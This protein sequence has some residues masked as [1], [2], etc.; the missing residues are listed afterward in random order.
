MEVVEQQFS[1]S[2]KNIFQ[3][4]T[5]FFTSKLLAVGVELDLFTWLSQRPRSFAEIQA[6]FD[7]A[8][9]PCRIFLETLVSLNLLEIQHGLY[10]NSSLAETLLVRGRPDFQGPH[11]RLF[12]NLYIACDALKI[13]LFENRPV[14]QDY[15][16]F[17]DAEGKGAARYST[18][19][20]DSSV[21]PALVLP[22]YWDF[23][24]S[25]KV[26]DVGGGYGRL[27]LTLVSQH[28]TLETMLF[29]LPEV[30]TKAAELLQSYPHGLARRIH[31]HPGNFFRDPL[32]GGA[33]TIVMMRVTHDWPR[34]RV[35]L[36]ARKAFAALPRGGRLLIYET[37]KDQGPCPGDAALISLLLLLISPGGECRTFAEMRTLLYEVGFSHIELIPTVYFYS[38]VVAEKP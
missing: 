3:M 29:D 17:F 23:S 22:Q 27:C 28:P 8:E 21:V 16:Y 7:F 24:E 11:I 9:R 15:S 14:S 13:A 19:M 18:L 33:D 5:G 30:C 25:R 26:L 1:P 37:F 6:R 32:P 34:E 20:H 2:E 36:L 31:L 10:S 12:D 35:A 38:L 4:M